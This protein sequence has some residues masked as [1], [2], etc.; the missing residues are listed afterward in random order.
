MIY[1]GGPAGGAF[2]AV[3]TRCAELAAPAATAVAQAGRAR[4]ERRTQACAILNAICK[5][6]RGI[7]SD[8]LL[9]R[10]SKA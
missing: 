3:L 10:T 6:E 2:A 8:L 5:K 1:R 7:A 9:K 4:E